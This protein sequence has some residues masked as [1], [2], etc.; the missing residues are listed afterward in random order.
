LTDAEHQT[1]A[2]LEETNEELFRGHLLKEWFNGIL[3]GR[4]VNVARYRLQAWIRDAKA[5]GLGHFAKAAR[6][7]ERHIDGILEYI[8]T[9]FSNGLVEGTNGKI[10]TIT[11]RSFGFHSA[12]AL[13]ALVFLCCGGVK[14]TPAF[15]VPEG[16]H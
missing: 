1:L 4:Q 15:S 9:R 13:I 8:R 7:I 12:S 14:V 16:F 2:E 10:R 11:K 6:T 3:G 5:S